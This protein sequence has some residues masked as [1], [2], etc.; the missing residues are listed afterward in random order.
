MNP[1]KKIPEWLVLL[2]VNVG[3]AAG[4][5]VLDQVT[6]GTLPMQAWAVNIVTL[7]MSV[8][9]MFNKTAQDKALIEN[10]PVPPSTDKPNG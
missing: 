2:I 5:V 1:T 9:R 10:N 8:I 4:T 6:K 7:I 3:L